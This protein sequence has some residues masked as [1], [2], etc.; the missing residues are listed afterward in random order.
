MQ[1]Q[2]A[3]IKKVTKAVDT[4]TGVLQKNASG[5][6]MRM[7]GFAIKYASEIVDGFKSIISPGLETSRVYEDMSA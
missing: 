4:Q 2:E 7:T 6:K 3:E 1:E 5:W